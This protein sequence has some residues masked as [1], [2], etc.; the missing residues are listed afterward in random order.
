MSLEDKR[1]EYEEILNVLCGHS[2]DIDHA[3]LI[4]AHRVSGTEGQYDTTVTQYRCDEH[5]AR[6]ILKEAIK[7]LALSAE[8]FPFKLQ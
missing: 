7:N 1:K 2:G 8:G 6:H 3:V 5:V 4:T